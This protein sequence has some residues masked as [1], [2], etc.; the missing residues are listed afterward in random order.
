[1]AYAGASFSQQM[2]GDFVNVV[3]QASENT[4]DK[5]SKNGGMQRERA[6]APTEQPQE[7]ESSLI[8]LRKCLKCNVRWW[9][10]E[11]RPDR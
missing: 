10:G 5:G 7:E 3:I 11:E 2:L 4:N 6:R 9:R 8:I 1:M